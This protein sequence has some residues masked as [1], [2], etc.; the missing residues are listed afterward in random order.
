MNP[1]ALKHILESALLAHG[2]PL[3][4]ERL[5]SLFEEDEQPSRRQIE[6]AAKALS[7]DLE[8]RGIELVQ[9]A[10]GY[11]LQV[12]QAFMPWISRLWDEKAP[13]YSR[14]LLETLALIAYR[15]PITRGDIE[16]VR[17]V[18]VSSGIIRTLLEREWIRVVG[19]KDVPGRPALFATTPI[20]LDYFGLKSLDELPTLLAI[21]DLDD[22][23]RKE[24]L[25]DDADARRTPTEDYQFDNQDEIARRG[26]EV[27]AATAD[28]LEQAQALVE[29][30]ERN[31]FGQNEERPDDPD[32]PDSSSG[33]TAFGDLLRRLQTPRSA[34]DN[35]GSSAADDTPNSQ[36]P[37]S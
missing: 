29:Q 21:R 33:S 4:V 19:Y 37:E 27:L 7:T 9:V 30:V 34:S 6:D 16:D 11:R 28:D 31:L 23:E 2:G 26:A 36:E 8:G 35:P 3:S 32:D 15:Q 13:R 1:T 18:T 20:F 10:S 25:G 22:L 12:R 14:A 17:G 5:Q 24:R